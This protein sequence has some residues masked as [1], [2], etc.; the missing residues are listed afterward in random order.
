MA[1]GRWPG[2]ATAGCPLGLPSRFLASGC[3][4]PAVR[5][6][7]ML[8]SSGDDP[9]QDFFQP[10]LHIS[11]AQANSGFLFQLQ[12]ACLSF[13]GQE[14]LAQFILLAAS[15]PSAETC[16]LVLRSLFF[17]LSVFLCFLLVVFLFKCVK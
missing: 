13:W 9:V 1:D 5:V 8:L 7:Q 4:L 17:F 10:F 2:P 11:R 15:P 12:H 14:L 16:T 3:A 6:D